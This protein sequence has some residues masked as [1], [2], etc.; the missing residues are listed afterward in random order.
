[1]WLYGHVLTEGYYYTM[2]GL[3]T[4]VQEFALIVD[5]GSTVTYVPCKSCTHCGKSHQDNPYVPASSSTYQAV[6]CDA[7]NCPGRQ[8]GPDQVCAYSRHYA[9][10]STSAGIIASDL[11]TFG[12]FSSIPPTRILFGC[13]TSETGD[14]YTQRADGIIGMGKG[15]LGIMNQLVGM[16]ATEDQFSLCYG[17]M[18]RGGG[19]M[20][21][22][23]V[24]P[25]PAMNFVPLDSRPGEGTYY[26]VAVEG[27]EV[28]GVDLKLAPSM[29]N[30]GYGS[31][32]DSGTTFTYLPGAAFQ[33]V[34]NAVAKYV[35]DKGL[36]KVAGPDPKYDDVCFGPATSDPSQLAEYFPP[37]TIQFH[38]NVKYQLSPEN[39]LFRHTAD[40]N[41]Y[42]LGVFENKDRG[43]L[44]GGILVRNTMVTYDRTKARVG[45]WK[46]N[47]SDLFEILTN[48]E[49]AN[50][51]PLPPELA[52]AP[53]ADVGEEGDQE[54][55][56][57]SASAPPASVSAG[58]SCNGCA[59]KLQIEFRVSVP[60]SSF[61]DLEGTFS[62]DVARELSIEREQ[63]RGVSYEAETDAH[64]SG[65][66]GATH[67]RFEVIPPAEGLVLS[68]ETVQRI[69]TV[70]DNAEF[71]LRDVFGAVTL[72]SFVPVP[73]QE[74]AAPSTPFYWYIVIVL[75]ALSI[76][77]GVVVLMWR[78]RSRS[79]MHA[80]KEEERREEEAALADPGEEQS[81]VDVERQEGEQPSRVV[82]E[83]ELTK[84]GQQGR[85]DE[86]SAPIL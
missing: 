10:D 1:M 78:R 85:E 58:S 49:G 26:N 37:I 9:E 23:A 56:G 45:F 63:V 34:K 8:C 54:G 51:P 5:T 33:A 71:S 27:L 48:M 62:A 72:E 73:P 15:Q 32:L 13:E 47:C 75:I 76:I 57:G 70:L 79:A 46:T 55:E 36:Q 86:H 3:G 11:A 41:A 82:H 7:N 25:P 59:S 65:G 43:T 53:P 50:A 44:L 67:V 42:C 83:Q 52:D 80:I 64:G 2:L 16:G 81:H 68:G 40:E 20:I 74:P 35:G 4:P 22:G 21:M 24:P 12:E 38:P 18:E 30:E 39:F 60:A 14:L 84:K 6:P 31:V 19:S 61:G 69:H 28:D 17:G 29:F 77:A 66:E